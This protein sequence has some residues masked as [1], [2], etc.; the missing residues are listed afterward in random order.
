MNTPPMSAEQLTPK[1]SPIMMHLDDNLSSS[2]T[3][4]SF[5]HLDDNKKASYPA[6]YR[7]SLSKLTERKSRGRT[8][9]PK[10]PN[11]ILRSNSPIRAMLNNAPKMLKPEYMSV[12][13]LLN[14]TRGVPVAPATTPSMILTSSKL[15]FKNVSQQPHQQ[16]NKEQEQPPVHFNEKPEPVSQPKAHNKHSKGLSNT[17][18]VI[19][20]ATA[21][22]SQV[23]CAPQSKP[24]TIPEVKLAEPRVKTPGYRF[25]SATST[26]SSGSTLDFKEFPESLN[27]EVAAIDKDEF[28][29]ATQSKRSSYMSSVGSTNDDDLNG[30]FAQSTDERQVA[31]LNI[32][33]AQNNRQHVDTLRERT[34]QTEHFSLRAKQL[35]LQIAELRLQNE[36]LRHTM[37]AHRTVQDKCMFDALHDVQ[38]EK[39][40]A[41]RD[42]DRK[43][44]Q[45][46]KQIDNYRRVIKKLTAPTKVVPTT[47]KPR[48]PLVDALTLNELSEANSSSGDDTENEDHD[49]INE[50]ILDKTTTITN[51]NNDEHS[52]QMSESPRK[53]PAG[54]RLGLTFEK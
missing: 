46:E 51:F 43:T 22:E 19:N 10:T 28:V 5:M 35:E 44:K 31:T 45:L 38:R 27:F 49:N 6:A 34:F 4:P 29:L 50:N 37:T 52:R 23:I 40:N 12:S 26:A 21:C 9:D 13:R 54:I 25:P 33:D 24:E 2:L 36:Q 48:I 20:G 14:N 15:I 1:M 39:E 7:T 53:R 3:N 32:S 42:M 11:K 30:W 41:Y 16:S 47:S 18:T 8:A 17:S